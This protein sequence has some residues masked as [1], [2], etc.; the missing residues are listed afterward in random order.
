MRQAQPQSKTYRINT[1]RTKMT[2]KFNKTV[3]RILMMTWIFLAKGMT[4]TK[5]SI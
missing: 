5:V 2:M 3:W 1:T 4:K